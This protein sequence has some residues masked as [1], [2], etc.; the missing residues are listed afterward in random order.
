[1]DFAAG[2]YFSEAPLPP[3]TPWPIPTPLYTLNTCILYRI[4]YS[5]SHANVEKVRGETVHKVESKIPT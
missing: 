4:L 2:V 3:M 1:M 5:Y